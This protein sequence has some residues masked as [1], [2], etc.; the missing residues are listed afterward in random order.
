MLD[1]PTLT[2]Q[3]HVNTLRP[4]MDPCDGN[5]PNYTLSNALIK[6]DIAAKN[7]KLLGLTT[8]FTTGVKEVRAWTIHARNTALQ[9]AGIIH[10]DF[11]GSFIHTQTIA[12]DD[13]I[14]Y[15]GEAGAKDTGKMHAE[16][17]EYLVKDEDVLNFLFNV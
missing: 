3:Q 14:A 1:Q 8:Y 11:E 15:K 9:A 16:S 7:Y 2:P 5:P 10:T 6:S 4:V 12:F 17:K 13:F